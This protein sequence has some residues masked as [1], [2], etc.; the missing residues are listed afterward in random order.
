MCSA[1][2]ETI[3][4]PFSLIAERN[5]RQFRTIDERI[6]SMV[7]RGYR[8]T[9]PDIDGHEYLAAGVDQYFEFNRVVADKSLGRRVHGICAHNLLASAAGRWIG[10]RK[11]DCD[12]ATD[13]SDFAVLWCHDDAEVI[14]RRKPAIG[15]E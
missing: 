13:L 6:A 1:S 5:P 7:T 14:L 9:D 2:S 12:L 8:A 3:R 4:T 15:K 10:R 11:V